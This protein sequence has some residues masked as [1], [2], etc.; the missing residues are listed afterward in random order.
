MKIVQLTDTVSVSEQITPQDIEEIASAGFK[1]VVNNRPDGESP[2]Q[3]ASEEIARAAQAAGLSY[4]YLPI[5]AGN[6]P[7]PDVGIMASLLD[8]TD[9]PVFAFCRTGTRCTN[10]WVATRGESET[11]AA[12]HRARTL[13]Y[14]LAMS[15]SR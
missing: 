13:G 10:L 1:V 15:A 5:T 9:E 8:N 12:T 7:G 6:F 11:E 2:E 3:P 4:Y 14:D